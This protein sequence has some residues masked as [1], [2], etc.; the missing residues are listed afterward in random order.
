MRLFKWL[1]R[2]SAIVLLITATVLLAQEQ[3]P[4]PPEQQPA[5]EQAPPP[6]PGQQPVQDQPSQ[7]DP[8]GRVARLQ[9][10]SGSVSIQPHGTDDWVQ[11]SVNR[12]L[13]IADNIWADKDSRAE[14]NVGTG[15][16][17]I[18][19]ESSLTLTN[20]SDN[21][22]QLQLH[23]GAMNLHIR[24][25]IGGEI[26]EVD[27]PNQA[28]TVS[29]AGDYRFDVD[30]NGD[31]TLVTVW[32]GEG[33]A[34]GQGPSV[35]I[36]SRE[37]AR[38]RGNFSEHE[39]H[40]AP[41]PD[42]FDQWCQVRDKRQDNS[43]SAR[44]VAPGVVGYED[45]DDYGTWREVPDYGRVWV[46]TVA[47]GWAPYRYGH[48]VWVDPWGWT[49]VDDASWG[50]APFHYGRWAYIGS[51]WGWIP[52]PYYV[53]PVY[54]PALVAW[55]GGPR[56]GFGFGFGVG[57]GFGG[58]FGWCPLGF[59]E[60][61]FPWYGVSRGY[62]RNVN[63]A[64]TRITNIRNVTNNYF[65]HTNSMAATHF[66]NANRPGGFTAVS[67]K[68]LTGSQ[69]VSR[70]MVNVSAN[71]LHN[72]QSINRIDA[73]PSRTS[74]LGPKAGQ[75]AAAPSRGT[76]SRPTVSRMSPPAS[77][78]RMGGTQ[79]MSA[80]GPQT[81]AARGPENQAARGPQT[82]ARGP[83]NSPTN[84]GSERPSGSMA[85]PGGHYVPR[86]PQNLGG[87]NSAAMS[88]RN[89]PQSGGN[90]RSESSQVAM[91]HNVPR[92]PQN[93][94]SGRFSQ[95]ANG[96]ES[97]TG[98]GMGASQQ[99]VARPAPGNTPRSSG[100][101]TYARSGFGNVPRP[102]GHIQP[103]PRTYSSGAGYSSRS[104]GGYGQSPRSGA[105]P[106]GGLYGHNY[107]SYGG[108]SYGSPSGHSYGSYGGHSSGS[109]GGG[110]HG[111]SGY[112]GSSGSHS[113]GSHGSGHRG[114]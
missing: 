49:W 33:E 6:P 109:Y 10:M 54:A 23:Q 74:M 30:A 78:A 113:S 60:P 51:Y 76:M 89:T 61:F 36:H 3:A 26:Y 13:T 111:S 77:E 62:F 12:P 79:S 25:L 42:S 5:Q 35:R 100:T 69:S 18:N 80:R 68:T 40:D 91:N 94:G 45:L 28:F 70:N 1:L 82:E 64:N 14:L 48:W 50:F 101:S 103:A 44:Y 86:P 104:Y 17:R 43:I 95:P 38:F 27:T 112:H 20:V 71:Q 92:P 97:R 106:Y 53:R 59:R 73:S 85:A 108:H 9:Y 107:G 4:P 19:S 88:A 15:T 83:Q 81:S 114:R 63:L 105:A 37:Q 47:P 90:V 110:S 65:N 46:P 7:K 8:P 66:A 34:T 32:R 22:V 87:A 41:S 75:P 31:S 67:G 2:A 99:S 57:F 39:I 52:G 98:S 24:R 29:K 21:A 102:T 16:I 58:G 84:R 96:S 56:W 93:A 55:F 72:A 11:G